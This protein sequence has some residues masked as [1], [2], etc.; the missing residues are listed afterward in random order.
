MEKPSLAAA[1]FSPRSVALVGAVDTPGKKIRRFTGIR[2]GKNR[3]EDTSLESMKVGAED[4]NVYS[5]K[6]IYFFFKEKI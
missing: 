6:I 5:F 3:K 1:L 4:L 2:K